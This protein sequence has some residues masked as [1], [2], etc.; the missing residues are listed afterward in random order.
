MLAERKAVLTEKAQR[1]CEYLRGLGASEV[2]LFGSITRDDFHLH[3]DVDIAVS[4]LPFKHIYAVE[5]K[6]GDILGTEEFD[7]V[8]LE[9]A[10]ERVRNR[11]REQGV[12]MC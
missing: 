9:Y 6:I 1:A 4:G 11:V 12:R 3:S 8:Y 5:S 7:L 10:K 2:Y